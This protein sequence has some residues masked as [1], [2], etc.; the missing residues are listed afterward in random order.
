MPSFS[1]ADVTSLFTIMDLDG[2][3]VVD[4]Y[5]FLEYARLN[6]PASGV[7]GTVARLTALF[8][9]DRKHEVTVEEFAASFKKAGNQLSPQDMGLKYT[10]VKPP[11]DALLS[12]AS[13]G[14]DAAVRG[15]LEDGVDANHVRASDG[16]S[17]L[18]L[19]STNGHKTTVST[20]IAAGANLDHLTN[21]NGKCPL[22]KASVRGHVEVVQML[23][24]AKADPNTLKTYDE[25]S[26]LY[27]AAHAGK[28]E[29][30]QLLIKH[31]ARLENRLIENSLVT[32]E[33][34]PK[35][36]GSTPLIVASFFDQV[37]AVK[38]LMLA[39]ADTS[40]T[41]VHGKTAL[42]VAKSEACRKQLM[43]TA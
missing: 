21:G 34:D 15:M 10:P 23:L 11:A 8:G 38:L 12:E 37:E 13:V 30:M 24:E 2:N 17:A 7:Y 42:D 43:S 14:N 19:A 6:K 29:V 40:A 18:Y 22:L 32:L 16:A 9:L 36:Y 27:A 31:N 33:R 28:L 5:E 20:L 1:L 4:K 3:G 26:S 39:G 35:Y 25:A 41:T